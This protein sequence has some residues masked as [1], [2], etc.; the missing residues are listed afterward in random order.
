MA[1]RPWASVTSVREGPGALDRRQPAPGL[2][3]ERALQPEPLLTAQRQPGL[4]DEREP[5]A[6][7]IVMTTPL[8]PPYSLHTVH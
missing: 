8:A 5:V 3:A 7:L 4:E 2:Q 1:V 6:H